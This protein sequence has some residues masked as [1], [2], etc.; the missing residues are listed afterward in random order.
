MPARAAT[1][2]SAPIPA[3][4]GIGLRAPHY[5]DVTETPP[6]VGWLE[7]HSENYFGDGGAPLHYLE[8]ARV[9]YPVSLH[10]VGLSLGSAD[11]LNREHLRKLQQ[12]IARIEPGLVS[13]HLSWSSIDGRYLNDLLPLP[14][15]EEALDHIVARIVET[16][17][18]LGRRIL[19][20]NPSSYLR[21]RHST[22]PEWEFLTAAAERA[23]CDILL[24]VNNVYVSACNHGFD[25]RVYLRAI[26]ADRVQEIHLAGHTVK[27]HEDGDILIDTHNTRVCDVVWELYRETVARLGLRPTLIEWDSDLPALAVLVEE[28]A[29][30][31]RILER[32]HDADAA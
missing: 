26:P 21:Y 20:E 3:R 6:D 30:A 32:V 15:T 9:H 22:I 11:P 10:G 5:R 31:D 23:D 13:D 18:F 25:P 29:M 14:Y 2:V 19:V 4:A 28:A 8:R 17:E 7:V 27:H 12:L 16:Q 1:R 24:D